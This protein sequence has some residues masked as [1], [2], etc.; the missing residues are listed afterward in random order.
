MTATFD[1]KTWM[2][3]LAQAPAQ[4]LCRLWSDLGFSPKYTWLRAPEIGAA[5]VRG[6]AGGTGA[7]FNLGEVTVTRCSLQLEGGQVG[8]AY[9]QGRDKAKAMQA[10][11][12]DAMMQTEM[13]GPL[14]QLLLEPLA[15]DRMAAQRARASK[16]AATEVDFFAMARGED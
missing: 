16:A 11:L 15:A 5:M 12:V 10:A 2:G 8:H 1:R 9:V 4:D 7:P 6:R 14:T 3:I 13:A